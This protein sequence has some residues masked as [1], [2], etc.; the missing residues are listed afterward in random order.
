M[1]QLFHG[2]AAVLQVLAEDAGSSDAHKVVCAY[3]RMEC[4]YIACLHNQRTNIVSILA[5]LH[6]W[7]SSRCSVLVL[8]TH[9]AAPSLSIIALLRPWQ[10][11]RCSVLGNH[12]AAPSL[13]LRRRPW[14]SL[15]C[16][17]LAAWATTHWQCPSATPNSCEATSSVQLSVCRYG[18]NSAFHSR[19]HRRCRTE[20]L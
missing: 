14:R 16:W 2:P 10:S 8:G 7:Q 13:V 19:A 4:V 11:S 17:Q 20:V 9:R 5:L 3:E 1:Q 18:C 12:R 6:P 15:T